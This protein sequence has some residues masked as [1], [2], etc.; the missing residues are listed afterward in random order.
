MRDV[1]CHQPLQ[2][3]SRAAGPQCPFFL[4][5]SASAPR[6]VSVCLWPVRVLS[7]DTIIGKNSLKELPEVVSHAVVFMGLLL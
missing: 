2:R 1:F 4:P 7:T 5:S 3:D 6:L